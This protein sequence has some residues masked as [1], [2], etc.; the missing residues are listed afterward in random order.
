MATTN[1][2]QASDEGRRDDGTDGIVVGN[3]SGDVHRGGRGT[4]DGDAD[5][6]GD[7]DGDSDGNSDGN[8]ILC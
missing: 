5:G 2:I 1:N 3:S 6:D 7:G 4:K 8:N